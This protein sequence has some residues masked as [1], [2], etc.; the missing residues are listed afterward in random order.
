MIF[1]YCWQ[2]ISD[3]TIWAFVTDAPT[4]LADLAMRMVPPDWEASRSPYEAPDRRVRYSKA[5]AARSHCRVSALI[6]PFQSA[7]SLLELF[8]DQTLIKGS[9]PRVR[10]TMAAVRAL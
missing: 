2:L 9:I 10:Y 5:A 3:K 4:R 7:C 8:A 1:V 6:R